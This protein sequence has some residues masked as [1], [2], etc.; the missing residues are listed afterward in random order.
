MVGVGG[1]STGTEPAA[2]GGKTA[3]VEG[4]SASTGD[5]ELADLPDSVIIDIDRRMDGVYED[6]VHQNDGT[7][8]NGGI[9]DDA[10]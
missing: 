5:K 1:M 6:H 3:N 9:A 4:T 2:V 10:V 7:H 8:L